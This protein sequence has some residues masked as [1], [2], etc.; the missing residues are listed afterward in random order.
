MHE[1]TREV[2]GF[3]CR[4]LLLAGVASAVVVTA[5]AGLVSISAPEPSRAAE[6]HVGDL[7]IAPPQKRYVPAAVFRGER[8]CLK[9][10]ALLGQIGESDPFE[11]AGDGQVQMILPPWPR[12]EG[13]YALH[14][15]GVPFSPHALL[16]RRAEVRVIGPEETLVLVHADAWPHRRSEEG[17]VVEL[18]GELD[19]RATVAICFD[20]PVE[21]LSALRRRLARAGL[22][23]PVLWYHGRRESSG[24]GL[25]WLFRQA[26]GRR[27]TRADA[28]VLLIAA[29]PRL[30]VWAARAGV[31]LHLLDGK[32]A[33]TPATAPTPPGGSPPQPRPRS[34][35]DWARLGAHLRRAVPPSRHA[36]TPE[37]SGEPK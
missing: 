22:N 6:L 27:R 30:A 36:A 31:R 24:F 5:I 34:W 11:F 37:T 3:L 13:R 4:W 25:E 7:I 2:V 15:R 12:Q 19:G 10:P 29:D 1:N 14:V 28:P 20:G 23:L 26:G 17:E 35:P 33:Q 18:L 8:T 21:G 9:V 16:G 32:T